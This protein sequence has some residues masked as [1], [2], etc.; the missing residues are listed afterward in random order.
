MRVMVTG[1]AGQLGHDVMAR[2]EALKMEAKG[3]DIADLDLTDEAATL[4]AIEAY[5]PDAVVHCAA[6]TAV[7][8]AEEEREKCARINVEGTKNV[9]RACGRTGAKLLYISTDYVFDGQGDKPFEADHPKAPIN[10]YGLTKA[11]GEE[12]CQALTAK[13]FIVR[14]AWV[15]G[16]NGKN[17]VKTM[18]RLGRERKSVSVVTDQTGS[19]TYTKDLAELLCDMIQT[20]R[21]GVYHATNEGFCSWNDFAREI[22]AQAGLSCRVEPVLAKDYPAQAKRPYNSRLSKDALEKAGFDRL[23]PWQDALARYLEELKTQEA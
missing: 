1:A 8:K 12:A 15:F 3:T 5:R 17:F 10:Y 21:Y 20:E 13:L 22:M 2:L 23:P 7:D 19:P 9:A 11:L 16:L 18:L 14:I 4:A 6:Y